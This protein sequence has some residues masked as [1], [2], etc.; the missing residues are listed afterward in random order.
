M[1]RG[2]PGGG[3]QLD[4]LRAL[5]S[6]TPGALD[7][8]LFARRNV[9]VT[10]FVMFMVGVSLYSSTVLIPQFLQENR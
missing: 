2:S 7:L 9:A 10:Q 6:R 8:R 5:A 4:N 3:L 1:E